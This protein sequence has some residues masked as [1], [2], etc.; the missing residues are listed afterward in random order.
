MA[1]LATL[2]VVSPLALLSWRT[3]MSCV[4]S[5]PTTEALYVVP[6]DAMVTVTLVAPSTTWL[7]VRISPFDVTTRPV[8]ALSAFW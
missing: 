8:P 2:A 7:L 1:A 3:A 5:V 6:V 4:G